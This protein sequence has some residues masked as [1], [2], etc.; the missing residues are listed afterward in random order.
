MR[1]LIWAVL[2]ICGLVLFVPAHARATPTTQL[3]GSV[4]YINNDRKPETTSVTNWGYTG[5]AAFD[6]QYRSLGI[7][8]GSPKVV[9]QLRLTDSDSTTR[10][11][12]SDISIYTS[13]NNTTY[14]IVRDWDFATI[15]KVSY[16]YNFQANARY[17][18]IH[19][20]TSETTGYNL[21]NSKLQALATAY[22]EG[23]ND[24]IA[25]GEG[26]WRYRKPVVVSNTA[27][28]VV[29][30]RATYIS[31]TALGTATL[32]AQGKLRSNLAD[33]RFRDT[34][35]RE[36]SY[37]QSSAGFFVRI[38]E[39]R[40]SANTTIY[41]YYGNAAATSRSDGEGTFEIEY[42]NR[43]LTEHTTTNFSLNGTVNRMQNGDLLYFANG[44]DRNRGIY[45]QT[46]KDGGRTWSAPTEFVN[47]G[48]NGRDEGGNM[49]IDDKTGTIYYQ[50]Y[51]Y[52]YYDAKNGLD[53]TKT[54]SDLYLTKSTDNGNTWSK[55]VKLD[56]KRN[57]T[58]TYGAGIKL[59]GAD[60]AGSRVDYIFPIAFVSSSTGAF[61]TSVM[62]SRDGGGT[63]I[64]SNTDISAG[65]NGFEGGAS[66]PAIIQLANGQ[67]KMFMRYQVSGAN[68]FAT[69]IS[70]DDGVNWTQPGLSPVFASNTMPSLGRYISAN[71][72]H[73]GDILMGWGSNNSVGTTSY[74]RAGYTLA[75]S[76]DETAG[77][78]YHLNILSRTPLDLPVVSGS[79]RVVVQPSM[80]PANADS[81]YFAWTQQ[82]TDTTKPHKVYGMRIDDFDRYLYRTQG[83]F[84]GFEDTNLR[85][86]NWWQSTASVTR[87]TT[88]K[89]R[90]NGSLKLYDN[91]KTALSRA[92]RW[93][94]STAEGI[95]R[96][97]LNPKSV[98]SMLVIE[99][100]QAYSA[101]G[102]DGDLFQLQVTADRSLK[103]K[104]S[105]G[106]VR[107]LPV[108][109]DLSLNTWSNIELHF[110]AGAKT[111]T[112]L[113]NG[114]NKGT[115]GGYIPGSFVNYVQ[116]SSGST[117]GTG[118]Q[119]Y[120]D[121]FSFQD[122]THGLPS[123]GSV[124]GETKLP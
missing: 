119:I 121:D 26:T 120:I 93:V 41:F 40:P 7:D 34:S 91:S 59:A 12:K 23:T 90:G 42:G 49:L 38:P 32:V 77:W 68:R 67:I 39:L 5:A 4:G 82:T 92:S 69:A 25:N 102:N 99:L 107:E 106:I 1:R 11:R 95:V 19:T 45:K 117:P 74:F 17:I 112:I 66:E 54:R 101:A 48:D 122:T 20:H 35:G 111:I 8:L 44:T 60:G 27:N 110:D 52:W 33:V 62:Y 64:R 73:A 43:T 3:S 31:N 96:F 36:L 10:I 9:S 94:P 18:K 87:D 124:G 58:V 71:S 6:Y 56:T 65:A 30:D 114:A 61:S 46:S 84:D 81:Y 72:D 98:A 75:A 37:Y 22:G 2:L 51:S 70:S 55:P 89:Y 13:S 76:N 83:A 28:A 113:V 108:V 50:F 105:G 85:S 118:T 116:F 29:Y 86:D 47:L 79:S 104:D 15:G 78:A 14:T 53:A 100:K 103:Y 24:F 57:Y 123:A 97:Q 80:A 16:I 21:S 115:V 109:T 88:T 63:W